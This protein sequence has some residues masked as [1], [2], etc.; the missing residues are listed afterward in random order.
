MAKL[1]ITINTSAVDDLLQKT[2]DPLHRRILENWRRHSLLEVSGNWPEIFTPEMTVA[3]PEY[4]MY[5]GGTLH[6]LRGREQIQ[7]FYAAMTESGHNVIAITDQNIV[8]ND[9]GFAHNAYFTQYYRGAELR[10]DGHEGLD[11]EAWYIRRA[12]LVEFWPYNDQG[13]LLGEYAAEMGPP[14]IIPIDESEVITFEEAR[15]A[16]TPLLRPLSDPIA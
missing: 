9:G 7:P 14:E 13:L 15:D 5:L 8:V 12:F 2:Q 3:Q 16:L 11:S 1:D 10:R 6:H 4:K